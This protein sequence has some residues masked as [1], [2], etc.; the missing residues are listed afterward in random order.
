MDSE[1]LR[2]GLQVRL[3][4]TKTKLKSLVR[5]LG[6]G[7][8]FLGIFNMFVAPLV[9]VEPFAPYRIFGVVFASETSGYYIGDVLLIAAGAILAWF[10]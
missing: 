10:V 4:R 8:L 1:K 3:L 6:V 9:S 5:L 2:I 7:L